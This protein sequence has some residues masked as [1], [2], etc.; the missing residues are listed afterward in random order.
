MN[1]LLR[2]DAKGERNLNE[3]WLFWIL[4]WQLLILVNG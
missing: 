3:F 1:L 2:I 4:Y